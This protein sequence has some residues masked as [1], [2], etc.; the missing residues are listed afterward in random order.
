MAESIKVI[1][2]VNGV[3]G[4]EE[5]D[6]TCMVLAKCIGDIKRFKVRWSWVVWRCM[7]PGR[8]IKS[9][10]RQKPRGLSLPV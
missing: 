2:A 1:K 4:Y 5:N 10:E 3:I 6:G 7:S 9:K 8:G